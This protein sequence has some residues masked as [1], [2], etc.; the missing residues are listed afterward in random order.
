MGYIFREQWRRLR[1]RGH[2]IIDSVKVD[3]LEA[4]HGEMIYG[5]DDYET[6]VKRFV[7]LTKTGD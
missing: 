5:P 3:Q 6:V 2:N 7:Q 1:G 4:H